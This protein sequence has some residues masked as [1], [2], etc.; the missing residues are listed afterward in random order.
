MQTYGQGLFDMKK[1]FR[2]V[3][4][5]AG[6]AAAAA[7]AGATNLEGSVSCKHMRKHSV[8]VTPYGHPKT[9]KNHLNGSGCLLMFCGL[10]II[11]RCVFSSDAS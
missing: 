1:Y 3:D 11:C 2:I 6:T 5:A 7:A 8:H 10:G 9:S 4:V